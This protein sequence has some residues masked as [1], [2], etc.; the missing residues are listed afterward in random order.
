[1]PTRSS[2]STSNQPSLK[3]KHHN[4]HIHQQQT[5]LKVPGLSSRRTSVNHRW[6]SSMEKAITTTHLC[7][8]RVMQLI[9]LVFMYLLWR[10]YKSKRLQLHLSAFSHLLASLSRM[11]EQGYC[12]RMRRCSSFWKALGLLRRNS[13]EGK[14]HM[15]TNVM[16][17]NDDRYKQE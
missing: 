12:P 7:G 16:T 6:R 1:M 13:M 3:R 9:T 8:G 15:M 4:H 14:L 2:S 17:S 5:T 10:S 11:T